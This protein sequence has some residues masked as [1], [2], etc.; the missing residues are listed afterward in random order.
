MLLTLH[1]SC[2]L[3][4]ALP[5]GFCGIEQL[6][7]FLTYN[8]Q[9][10]SKNK[11]CGTESTM[12][13]TRMAISLLFEREKKKTETFCHN[14]CMRARSELAHTH[15]HAHIRTSNSKSNLICS[16]TLLRI[17]SQSCRFGINQ[18]NLRE[19]RF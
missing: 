17:H 9:E 13:Y 12:A 2:M 15:T 3:L 16:L 1:T 18:R 4:I 5:T 8:L 7:C 10:N 19:I 14:I 11:K 6:N